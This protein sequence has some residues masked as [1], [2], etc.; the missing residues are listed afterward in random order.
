MIPVILISLL[1]VN[2]VLVPEST[3][4]DTSHV[5]IGFALSGGAALGLAHIGVLKIL[6]QE[7]IQPCCIS[8][9][10]MGSM[11]GG[12]YAA[13][14][15]AAALESIAVNA[16]FS[17][18]FGSSVPFGARYL[19][20]RQQSQRY[21][22]VFDHRNF[23]P[24]L[25][26]G[27]ISLQNV[28][29]LLM[30]LLSDIEFNSYYDFDSLP[31]PYRAIAVDLK[32]GDLITMD[33]G[34]LEQA[35][36]A[37][38]AIPGVF[39]PETIDTLELVDGGVQQFLPVQP[40]LEYQPDL[41]IASTTIRSKEISGNEGLIDVISRTMDLINMCDYRSQLQLADIIIK[42]NVDPFMSSDFG[43]AAELIAAGEKAAQAALPEIRNKL[44]GRMVIARQ[45]KPKQR[46]LPYVSDVQFRGLK[47][48][49][50]STVRH[51]V[52]T[53]PGAKLDF[54]KLQND[55]VSLYNTGLFLN[56]NYELGL[57]TP[58]SVSIVIW[59]K[60]RQYGFYALGVRY[61]NSDNLVLGIEAGQGNLWGTG[62]SIR[63]A[64]NLGNP[65]AGRLGLT[66]TRLFA[67]PFGYRIDVF[68]GSIERPLFQ[69]GDWLADY[70]TRYHGA[71]VE[72]GYILGENAFFNLGFTVREAVYNFPQLSVFDSI[73][74]NEW[75]IGPTFE[76]E[77]SS[78]DDLHLPNKGASYKLYVWYAAEK[79]KATSDFVRVDFS[80]D[81]YIPLTSR[82]LLHP[83]LDIGQS[84]GEIAWDFYYHTGGGDFIGYENGAFTTTDR[85]I[86]RLGLEF[87]ILNLLDQEEYPLYL[88]I[89]SNVATFER[90]DE[91]I[92]V[93]DPASMLHWGIG[94][95]ARTN[96][97]I[98]PF[99]IA[100]GIGDINK[101]NADAR[102]NYYVSIGKEFRY[103][104]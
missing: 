9:N 85:T 89:L 3:Q 12:I 86:L 102:F 94:I 83:G 58:D 71:L 1:C 13:G 8:G 38:I 57:H 56:V 77:Y 2:Q 32:S 78:F 73:P 29:F 62:A 90:L 79:L 104:K 103:T 35:I 91:F 27:L 65:R 21:T 100:L 14:Y 42:P 95:G 40:L 64:L 4:T 59:I 19:P 45:K 81:Q 60:E 28:E 66:G 23:I 92:K 75:A 101:E 22:V 54:K 20:E 99:R 41:I 47:V 10:S 26:S 5:R 25:P 76:L 61:D 87:R 31:I 97:P 15:T 67:F 34:R 55:L 51:L 49:S 7:G 44:N 74:P 30:N 68:R 6:E 98:G 72:A 36:R 70:T 17:Q 82:V 80:F 16:D 43:R 69:N 88:Q 52:K 33:S 46:P 84:T 93:D 96:T 63:A 18:L 11:V 24:T 48:T 37:S 39:S 53:K 50:P